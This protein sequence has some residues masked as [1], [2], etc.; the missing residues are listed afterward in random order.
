MLFSRLLNAAMT[1][2]VKISTVITICVNSW[3]RSSFHLID[4]QVESQRSA[5]RHP[6]LA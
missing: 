5:T 3:L 1:T 2:V 4:I 6:S